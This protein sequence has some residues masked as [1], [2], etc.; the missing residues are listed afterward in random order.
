MPMRVRPDVSVVVIAYNDAARLPR[1]VASSLAQSLGGVETVIVDDASTDGTGEAADRLA[2]AHPGRVGAVHLPVNSGGCGRPRNVG[3]ERSDG[4]YVM[5]L[6]SD[7]L[8]DRHA[9]L[10]L[11]SAAQETGA[12]LVSG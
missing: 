2:A 10:N 3:V 11:L 9:C 5:F 1:A 12:D 7:D 8:L 6:D 4:R